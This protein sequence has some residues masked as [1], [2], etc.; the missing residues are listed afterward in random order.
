MSDVARSD[1]QRGGGTA[2]GPLGGLAVVD[3]STTLAGAFAT[4]FLADAGADVL[5]VEVPG[6]DR[7]VLTCSLPRNLPAPDMAPLP[8]SLLPFHVSVITRTPFS[9]RW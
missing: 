6:E 5:Q 8:I 1:E 4:Q 3:L 7:L 2:A 9:R